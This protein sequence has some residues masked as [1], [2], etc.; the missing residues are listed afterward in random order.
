MK[1]IKNHTKNIIYKFD[2]KKFNV[3]FWDFKPNIYKEIYSD[4]RHLNNIQLIKHYFYIGRLQRRI[5]N[6]GIKILIVCDPWNDDGKF[7]SGG[8]KA[9]YNLAKIIN[10]KKYKNIYAKLYDN[11]RKYINN[12]YSN[13]Y[14]YE[15]EVNSQTLVIYP[16]G[17][18][19]NPLLA[20]HVMRWILLEI[21]TIYRPLT[22]LETWK[23]NDIVYHW[24]PSNIAKNIK[25][26]NNCIVDLSFVNLNKQRNY[27]SSCFLIKK[28]FFFEKNITYV[29]PCDSICLD[30][31]N[32]EDIINN[33]N[34]CEYFYCYD[35]K[36]F[37]IIGAIIC[38]C[39][40]ILIPD[41]KTKQ[42]YIEQ[43]VF[44]KFQKINN[45]F[46]WGEIDINSISYN[47]N[48]IKELINYLNNLSDS[49]NIFLED[50][51]NYFNSIPTNISNV[52]NVY[53][54]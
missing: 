44:Y 25:I 1:L 52:N 12:I 26:L 35:L 30:N 38:G 16:D 47:D 51:Y 39:K 49:V 50:I 28:R 32:K 7:T 23:K 2:I 43:S 54:S 37:F 40:V 14:A 41:T 15:N 42:L 8:N 45:F 20:K 18:Y 13:C 9:L 5:Y 31:L 46:A 24:E 11:S 29:H 33:F 3:F 53:Y 22:I 36:T 34:L 21:G 10:E 4:V 27:N 19:G 48:D 17:S 6:R